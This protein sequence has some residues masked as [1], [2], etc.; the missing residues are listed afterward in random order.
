MKDKILMVKELA[1]KHSPEIIKLRRK[2]HANPELAFEEFDTADL[3]SNF[4]KDN[5][6][7]TFE[8]YSKNRCCWV[9]KRK[10]PKQTNHR[11]QG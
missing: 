4:L 7:R 5:E 11:T 9:D 1:E 8:R 10:E 3:I 6:I 2:I